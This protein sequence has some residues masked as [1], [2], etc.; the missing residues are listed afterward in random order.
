MAEDCQK[1]VVNHFEA[2]SNCQVFNGPVTGCVFAMPGSTVTQQGAPAAA[3]S[4]AAPPRLREAIM[5]YVERL[6][7]LVAEAQQAG[8][9]LLWTRV[10]EL[11]EVRQLV[12]NRGRQQ[13]TTFNR[14]LVAQIIHQMGTRVYLPSARAVQMAECLEPSKGRDHPVRQ[15]LGENPPSAVKKAVERLLSEVME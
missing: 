9:S 6:R 3:P 12:Y 5:E 1:N 10:L 8:Y 14:D 4:G 15:R 7:P 11:Q 2:G 13:G